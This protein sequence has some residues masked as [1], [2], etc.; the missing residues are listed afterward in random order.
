[1]PVADEVEDEFVDP[2]DFG[3]P[4]NSFEHRVSSTIVCGYAGDDRLKVRH[5]A[6]EYANLAELLPE[7]WSR[8]GTESD[9]V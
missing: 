1:M 4:A 3:F 7:V 9:R 8:Y 2:V 5:C 6:H